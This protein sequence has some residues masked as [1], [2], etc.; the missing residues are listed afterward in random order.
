MSNSDRSLRRRSRDID[1]AKSPLQRLLSLRIKTN[2]LS[3]VVFSALIFVL[4]LLG[5]LEWDTRW[6][7]VLLPAVVV[8]CIGSYLA[9]YLIVRRGV[10]SWRRLVQAPAKAWARGDAAEAERA[11]QKALARAERF[12]PEDHRRGLMLVD[13]AGYL[14]SQGRY[15]EAQA[16]FADAV[17]ILARNWRRNPIDFFIA[18]N[19][20]AIFHIH[21]RDFPAAQALLEKVFDLL[22]L[23]KKERDDKEVS[24][25]YHIF[26]FTLHLNLVFLF[27]QMG[28]LAEAQ[29]W[30]AE[31]DA[32]YRD[33]PSRNRTV[34][35]DHYRAIRAYLLFMLG[36]FADAT[37]E[38]DVAKNPE[39][40]PCLRVRSKLLLVRR[41]F[42]QAE[43]T[44]RRYIDLEAKQGA[45][46]RPEL[47]DYYLDLAESRFGQAK[48]DE[49]FAALAEA[50]TLVA[51]FA[52]PADPAWR[53]A[54]QT[55]LGRAR[56]LG[57]TDAAAAL[58]AE[59]QQLAL[60]PEQGITVSPRLRVRPAI[61]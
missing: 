17:A 56:A 46:H 10:F 22:L 44:L 13:L 25:P 58:E 2:W 57:R 12:G 30:L 29:Y 33:V 26:N 1:I 16:L 43:E 11:L 14:K 3:F 31:A 19:N 5:N 53:R 15:P 20:Y 24:F 51:D 27:M 52:L 59:V 60:L 9:W 28:E 18:L 55:W 50:R 21:R 41:E 54:M 38:V 45:M 39:Y 23:Y 40:A 61:T 4:W 7:L 47:R 6:A 32:V 35:H 37:I 49:A 36:Q 8:G 42:A 34:Y 48:H